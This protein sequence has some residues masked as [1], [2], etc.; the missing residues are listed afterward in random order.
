MPPLFVLHGG[1]MGIAQALHRFTVANTGQFT[2][3]RV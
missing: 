3:D 2:Y 1:Y